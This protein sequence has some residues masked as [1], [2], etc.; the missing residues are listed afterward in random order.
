MPNRKVRHALVQYTTHDGT[1]EI[2]FR[3]EVVDFP[4][5]EVDRLEAY[6]ALVSEGTTLQR[7]G[8]MLA[9]PVSPSDQEVITWVI[10]ATDDEVRALAET[11]PELAA[12]LDDAKAYIV[13]HTNSVTGRLDAARTVAADATPQAPPPVDPAA[14]PGTV[15]VP[16][17]DPNARTPEAPTPEA[18]GLSSAEAD[19]IVTG[20]AKQVADWIA[21]HPTD[22]NAILEAE[23]RR[24]AADPDKPVR[25][26]VVNAAAAAAGHTQ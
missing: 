8:R 3:N 4:Q 5:G 24:A 26:T 12:R 1:R 15:P 23:S 18:E 19:T 11:R 20:N 10:G 22:A 13:A 7:P 6:G 17:T 2:A 16:V 25:S 21:E 9:L 14:D